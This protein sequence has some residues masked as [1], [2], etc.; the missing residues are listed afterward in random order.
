MAGRTI[1][2]DANRNGRLDAGEVRVVTGTDGRY[3]FGGLAA[4][5]YLIREIVPPSWRNSGNGSYDLALAAGPSTMLGAGQNRGDKDF[6]QTQLGL[7]S[8]FVFRDPSTSSGQV[9]IP[10]AGVLVYLD[11]NNDGK[12]DNGEAS[13]KTGADGKYTFLVRAGAYYVRRLNAK[14]GYFITVVAGQRV[15]VPNFADHS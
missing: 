13:F 15:N 4:G 14:A 10:L 5:H 12:L 9:R 3:A 8:G 2:I 6:A 7:V 1:Y 11:A